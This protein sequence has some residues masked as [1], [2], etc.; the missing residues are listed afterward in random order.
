M[1]HTQIAG[2]PTL[3]PQ[4]VSTPLIYNLNTAS[5]SGSVYEVTPRAVVLAPGTEWN[6]PVGVLVP[7]IATDEGVGLGVGVA[8]GLGV[9]VE[10]GLGVAV[11]DGVAVGLGVGVAVGLGVAVGAGVGV[12]VT[13]GAAN[14][15]DESGEPTLG[16][17]HPTS[18]T[19]AIKIIKS[20]I[21]PTFIYFLIYF[22]SWR[23]IFSSLR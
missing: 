11:G 23:L 18:V 7:V 4:S 1:V 13:E 10:V 16:S 17:P 5:P 20:F 9:G 12:A 14:A 3:P 19:L 2:Y 21:I 6:T 15:D 8:V 22:L